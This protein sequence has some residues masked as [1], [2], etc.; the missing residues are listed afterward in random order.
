MSDSI[1]A[2]YIQPKNALNGNIQKAQIV[3]KILKRLQ[4]LPD[5]RNY[6]DDLETLLFVCLLVEHLVINKKNKEKM[7]KKEI[8]LSVYEKAYGN[9]NCNKDLISKNIDFLHENKRIKKVS[10]TSMICG[11]L[12]EWFT[13]KIA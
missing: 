12:S 3:E 13:R 8:V 7:D 11:T 2:P 5:F 9:N 1:P 4:S 6:K 10:I